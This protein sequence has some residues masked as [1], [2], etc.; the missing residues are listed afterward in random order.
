MEAFHVGWRVFFARWNTL[1]SENEPQVGHHGV[2][3]ET[4]G[5]VNFEVVVLESFKHV[6][7]NL[8]MMLMGARV[9]DDI[10][11]VHNDVLDLV[12]DFFH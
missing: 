12:E 4:F 8:Q 10:V 7:K 9:D 11:D 2:A 6:V 1:R 5:Q 3:E